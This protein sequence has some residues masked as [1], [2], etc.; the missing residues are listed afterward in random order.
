VK[1]RRLLFETA[2]SVLR[3][4]QAVHALVWK[5]CLCALDFLLHATGCGTAAG[6]RC[7]VAKGGEVLNG[8]NRFRAFKKCVLLML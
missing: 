5:L 7:V 4:P 2:S 6:L 3:L 1:P 8:L